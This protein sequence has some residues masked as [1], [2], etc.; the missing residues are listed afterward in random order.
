MAASS[1]VGGVKWGNSETHL[2]T[3]GAGMEAGHGIPDDR[4]GSIPNSAGVMTGLIPFFFIS[5]SSPLRL[6]RALSS[7]VLP[8]ALSADS[9]ARRLASSASI[10]ALPSVSAMS[11]RRRNGEEKRQIALLVTLFP[12]AS[13][14]G[15]SSMWTTGSRRVLLTATS[16]S[17]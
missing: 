17:V 10:C 16:G 9:L 6:A 12:F 8:A 11:A 2:G 7:L 13:S 5:L 14:R 15:A 4:E 3:G 1:S